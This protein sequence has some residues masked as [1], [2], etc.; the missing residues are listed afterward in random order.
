MALALHTAVGTCVCLR[1]R[2]RV[3]MNSQQVQTELKAWWA[4]ALAM[5][6]LFCFLSIRIYKFY[7]IK[8]IMSISLNYG[9]YI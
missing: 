8:Q 6:P 1:E 2:A 9:R 3:Q 4:T 7:Q 5:R